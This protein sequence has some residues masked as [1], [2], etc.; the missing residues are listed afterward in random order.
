MFS[1]LDRFER[2]FSD[3]GRSG[4]REKMARA[5]VFMVGLLV[6][7]CFSGTTRADYVKYKDPKQPLNTRIEDLLRRMTLAEKIGQMTQIDRSVASFEVMKKYFIG[8]R[9]DHPLSWDRTI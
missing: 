6:L 3:R 9:H 1:D 8:E 5:P 4:N 2:C 7:C